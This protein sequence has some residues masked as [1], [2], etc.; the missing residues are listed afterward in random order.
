MPTIYGLPYPASSAVPDVPGDLLALATA[1]GLQ[2]NT[3]PA[4]AKLTAPTETATVS[5][6]AATGTI[7][8]DG[9][10]QGILFYTSNAAADWTLNVRGNSSTTLASMLATGQTITVNFLVTQGT[11]AYKH[12]A[13]TIDGSAQTVRWQ[14]G[15]APSA[16]NVSGVDAYTFTIVK[17]AATPTYS[18]F[19]V[20]PTKFA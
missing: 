5:A 18:V 17:T 4:N 16:G 11:T 15:T 8:Y 13:L 10:T 7:Q 3:A 19:G 2:L 20:G 1:A 14:G 6:T 12:S 9:K